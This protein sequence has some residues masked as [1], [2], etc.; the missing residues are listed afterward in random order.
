MCLGI[1]TQDIFPVDFQRL[2]LFLQ[3]IDFCQDLTLEVCSVGQICDD[4]HQISGLELGC[5]LELVD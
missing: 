3:L 2:E 1:L 4:E 5:E